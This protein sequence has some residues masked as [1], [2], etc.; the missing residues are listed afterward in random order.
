M[1]FK[2]VWITNYINFVIRINPQKKIPKICPQNVKEH[3]NQYN[4]NNLCIK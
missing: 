4:N 1:L 3:V 2:Q